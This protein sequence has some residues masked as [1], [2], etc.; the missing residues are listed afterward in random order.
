[1]TGYSYSDWK[2]LSEDERRFKHGVSISRDNPLNNPNR[3]RYWSGEASA[4]ALVAHLQET[5][6]GEDR[7]AAARMFNE[8][9]A[10]H[11]R[12][13]ESS[14]NID[15]AIHARRDE[16]NAVLGRMNDG[17]SDR[18]MDSLVQVYSDVA[19]FQDRAARSGHDPQTAT[20]RFL[21][22]S[23][24][25]A[26]GRDVDASSLG[27]FEELA[28][29]PEAANLS[30]SIS[31]LHGSMQFD[32]DAENITAE[33]EAADNPLGRPSEEAR[34]KAQSDLVE[35]Q[36]RAQMDGLD[37]ADATSRFVRIGVQR[38]LGQDVGENPYGSK[39]AELAETDEAMNLE[40]SIG[41]LHETMRTSANDL[42]AG[43]D[44][45]EAAV[46]PI[47]DI[48]SG[49][50]VTTAAESEI[51]AE[52]RELL[53]VLDSV[54][55]AL[56]PKGVSPSDVFSVRMETKEEAQAMETV[57]K[58]AG[59]T[60]R[61]PQP[62]DIHKQF[63]AWRD[64]GEGV[65]PYDPGQ[66]RSAGLIVGN[67][68]DA[69][70]NAGVLAQG[71][72]TEA[73]ANTPITVLSIRG[74]DELKAELAKTGRPVV[75][76][77]VRAGRD[78]VELVSGSNAANRIDV[79]DLSA[80]QSFDS[81]ERS[82]A[83]SAFVSQASSVAYLKGEQMTPAEAQAVNI[84]SNAAKLNL[85]VERSGDEMNEDQM[86]ALKT[87]ARKIDREADPQRYYAASISQP[88]RLVR[89]EQENVVASLKT[90]A[91]D[92]AR[93]CDKAH[94]R[95]ARGRDVIGEAHARI[96]KKATVLS[97]HEP[98]NA[99]NKW[100]E[101]KSGRPKFY[102]T[103]KRDLSFAKDT[104][105]GTVRTAETQ[106][107]IYDKPEGE[108]KWER[109]SK[110][111]YRRRE[112]TAK[113]QSV[114]NGVKYR[115][116]LTRPVPG[117]TDAI[118]VANFR[119][120]ELKDP[121]L[122]GAYIQIDGDAASNARNAD[123]QAR[124]VAQEAVMDNARSAIIL[125]D[126]MGSDYHAASMVRLAHEMDRP[127]TVLRSDGSAMPRSE[128]RKEL[129]ELSRNPVE[130]RA[131]KFN[132][133]PDYALQDDTAHLTLSS[134]P[135]MNAQSAQRVADLAGHSYTL[136]EFATDTSKEREQLLIDAGVSP[137][138]R[139]GMRD[140]Q[141][142]EKASDRAALVMSA[143]AEYDAV[144]HR[145]GSHSHP[146]NAANDGNQVS[147]AGKSN[148]FEVNTNPEVLDPA[149]M[150]VA[151]FIGTSLPVRGA[152]EKEGTD[153][154]DI[155]DRKALRASIEGF[156]KSGYG[157][158][159]SLDE[160]VSRA[161]LEEAAKV[162]EANVFMVSAGN[163]MAKSQ[164]VLSPGMQLL[165][166]GRGTMLMAEHI[167]PIKL[168]D[169]DGKALPDRYVQDK[170]GARDMLAGIASVGVVV[171]APDKD[172]SL[173][174]ADEINKAGKPVAALVPQNESAAGSEL[175]SGNVKLLKGQGRAW[176]ESESLVQA[177]SARGYAN[178]SDKKPEYQR[179][180]NVM[181]G[182]AGTFESENLE[183]SDMLRSGRHHREIGWGKAA[184]AISSEKSVDAFA[185]AAARG[186]AKALGAYREPTERQREE[187]RLAY[188]KVSPEVREVFADNSKVNRA[189]A[190]Q[191][192]ALESGQGR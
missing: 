3:G 53:A 1:M 144:L 68:P 27:E 170:N 40:S 179:F 7:L 141:N 150:P 59:Q 74:G 37:P 96:P 89:D 153:P 151:A 91:F 110:A 133:R 58:W 69:L 147:A 120:Y 42:A 160:G 75:D 187:R 63:N 32:R 10:T 192:F 83:A 56:S 164:D 100:M 54:P 77:S 156:A 26:A 176:I 25:Q 130:D 67:G 149:R 189:M 86:E 61:L 126:A 102:A 41:L 62:E 162:P 9:K 95:D 146:V 166:E 184:T 47:V 138:G 109:M 49:R 71:L 116:P 6:A 4:T 161:V 23:A 105:G 168:E 5:L 8:L 19:E 180:D 46:D 20:T 122:R 55:R 115:E 84:A 57:L 101:A 140:L 14:R 113:N 103:A 142:W 183:I 174:I 171:A 182:T 181:G 82:N 31:A 139:K 177:P 112:M 36:Q 157:I 93:N 188:E 44:A 167:A 2:G 38:A 28:G 34:A 15:K 30:A 131:A 99:V 114:H 175:Y 50:P 107:T 178:L 73:Y 165:S 60:E 80:A 12:A 65:S 190:A 78:G 123:A 104:A 94:A 43:P 172:R 129:Q 98:A 64:N 24:A 111:D 81:V 173:L 17:L 137:E 154:A 70:A 155:V 121:K 185:K 134:M 158:G 119:T 159:V 163:P 33:M 186:E 39:Y 136:K 191:Q 152:G 18:S 52:E 92:G 22:H 132:E 29:S 125:N 85:A 118:A 79:L 108:R 148:L 76:A 135:G 106:L 66:Q 97:V 51:N 16:A 11:R 143:A 88:R 169:S 128:A 72:S 145:G 87:N 13:A 127:T 124:K 117:D 21:R 45:L 35:F 48:L 90:V